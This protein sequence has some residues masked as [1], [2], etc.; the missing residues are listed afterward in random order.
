MGAVRVASVG[1][2]Q[3]TWV[4][5]WCRGGG[6]RPAPHAHVGEGLVTV[7]CGDMAAGTGTSRVVVVSHLLRVLRVEGAS[8]ALWRIS[9]KTHFEI[10]KRR[11]F[12]ESDPD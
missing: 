8:R 7:L 3:R 6:G 4:V 2:G 9:K 5:S 12:F 10:V 11:F 1:V